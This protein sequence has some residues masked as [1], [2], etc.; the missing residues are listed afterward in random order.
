MNAADAVIDLYTRHGL[1]WVALRGTAPAE[2]AW[3]DR[4]MALLPKRGAVLDLG[5]GGGEPIAGALIRAGHQVTGVDASPP[6]LALARERHPTERWVPGD[7]RDLA[8]DCTFD[9]LIAWDSFFHLDHDAQRAMFPRF[10]AHASPSAVLMFTSGPS[11]GI[12]LG[13]FAGE[14]LFHAS[15]DPAEYRAL[16][17]AEGFTVVDHVVEDPTCGGR[18]VWLAQRG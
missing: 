13:T 16:L 15:L 1:A 4:F 11:H 5:C 2:G 9:G 8:L 14:T 7:M 10:A 12:A 17:A 3:P 18:T 6:L